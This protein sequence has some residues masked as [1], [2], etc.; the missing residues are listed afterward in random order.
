MYIVGTLGFLALVFA[1]FVSS[2]RLTMRQ[3]N[4]AFKIRQMY[5]AT[6]IH[7]SLRIGGFL[8]AVALVP[9]VVLLFLLLVFLLVTGAPA[10]GA[11]L[12]VML[13]LI[14]TF[15]FL[16]FS[17]VREVRAQEQIGW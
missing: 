4:R 9:Q 12:W 1:A 7:I 11:T 6:P 13:A 5:G 3:E 16:W 14:L 10:P 8:A 15:V 2:A 17:A